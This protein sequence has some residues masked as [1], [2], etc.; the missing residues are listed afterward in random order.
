MRKLLYYIGKYDYSLPSPF[1]DGRHFEVTADDG[2]KIVGTEIG[3]EG[4][5]VFVLAHGLFGHHRAPGMAEFAQSLSR[6]GGVFTFDLRGHGVSDG[7]CTLGNMEAQDVAAVMGMVR[8]LE[9]RPLVVVGFSM[10]AGAAVRATALF[11]PADAVV[12]ISGPAEWAG[13]RRRSARMLRMAW[14]APLGTRV[15]RTVTGVRIDRT[16][17]DCESPASVAG[18]I[19]PSPLLIVH[20]RDDDFF[21]P[22]EAETL[23]ANANEPKDLWMMSRGGHADGFFHSPGYPVDRSRVDG[24]AD[25]IISRIQRLMGRD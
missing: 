21:P 20:S 16:W 8:R 9:T 7:F 2:A 5:F 10:G 23:Y 6:F 25:E 17:L 22:E 19:A 12:S 24:F 14:R 15:M 4:D 11:E 13:S 18:K 3:G 1:S